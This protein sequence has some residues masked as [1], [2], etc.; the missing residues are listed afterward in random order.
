MNAKLFPMPSLEDIIRA[1][2]MYEEIEPRDLFY[3]AATELVALSWDGCSSRSIETFRD[4]DEATVSHIFQDFE[5]VLGT[6]GAAKC[7]HLL[8]SRF[9]PL[10]DRAIAKAYGCSLGPKGTNS[11]LYCQFMKKTREQ[12]ICLGGEGIIGRNPLK[13][14]DEYNWCNFAKKGGRTG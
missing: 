9:F 4:K 3:R 6:V 12:C 7:L 11:G 1:R 13:A 2:E 10:W 8:A 5:E 14:L